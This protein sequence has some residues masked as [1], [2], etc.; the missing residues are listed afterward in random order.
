MQQMATPKTKTQPVYNL[1]FPAYCDQVTLFGYVFKRARDYESRVKKL[2][3]V[4]GLIREF[5]LK[6]ITGTHSLTATVLIPA[7]E[8]RCRLPWEQKNSTALA[9]IILLLNLFTNRDVFSFPAK[10]LK[11]QILF[12]DPRTYAVANMLRVGIGYKKGLPNEYGR[13]QN[14]NFERVLNDTVKLIRSRH[15]Q[16]KYGRGYVLF[17]ARQA[18]KYQTAESSYLAC[19]AIWEH[20]FSLLNPNLTDKQ[21]YD[22]K[23]RMKIAFVLHEFGFISRPLTNKQTARVDSQFVYMRNRVIHFGYLSQRRHARSDAK[24]FVELTSHL[25]ARILNLSPK[26]ITGCIKRTRRIVGPR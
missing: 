2:H 18:F 3:R 20:V 15:W 14:M 13:A 22:T 10:D 21:K 4:S 24:T 12:Y 8:V 9:D 5:N 7:K 23:G 17:L 19:F 6:P 26:D 11:G 16:R 1:E 25:I